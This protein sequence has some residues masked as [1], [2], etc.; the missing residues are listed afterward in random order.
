MVRL[1]AL[2]SAFIALAIALG[3]L[4]AQDPSNTTNSGT[5][6]NPNDCGGS[7]MGD[8]GHSIYGCCHQMPLE[9]PVCDPCCC[10]LWYFSGFGG[11]TFVENFHRQIRIPPVATTLETQGPSVLDGYGIGT[12][13]GCRVHSQ[14]RFEGEY[15]YRYNGVGDW[16]T[17]VETSGVLTSLTRDPA[18]GNL[19]SHSLM[20]NS[21]MDVSKPR[22]GC[23]NL[24]GGGGIGIVHVE[25]TIQIPATTYDVSDSTFAWQLIGGVNYAVSA[26][27]DLFVEY[28]YL[29]A[30]ALNVIDTATGIPFGDFD[31]D[32]HS[33]FLGARIYK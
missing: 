24:Y 8:W 23:A 21:L 5:Y 20:F 25:S 19:L 9:G 29:G 30:D 15:T 7:D 28:R 26:Q 13:I 4:S 22:V 2:A 27:M 11:G 17:G 16:F 12:A 10:G 6:N 33:V 18:E 3:N 14:L 1:P 32:T 31:Y